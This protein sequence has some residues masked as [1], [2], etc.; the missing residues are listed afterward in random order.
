[1]K[2]KNQK[3]FT[4]IE[5]LGAVAILGILTTVGIVSVSKVLEKSHAKFDKN[6]YEVFLN[7]A[8]TYF[9]DD[10]TRLPLTPNERKEI[11][12]EKLIEYK[13]LDE[14]L[15]SNKNKF[16]YKKSRVVVIRLSTGKYK[17]EAELYRTTGQKIGTI[18][19]NKVNE[20][21][22]I[23]FKLLN[24]ESYYQEGTIYYVKDVP[25]VEVTIVDNDKI[26]GY[27]YIIYKDGKQ[28]KKSN[29]IEIA[30]VNTYNDTIEL[31][32]E[33]PFGKY[34][35]KVTAYDKFG[36]KT[37][38]TS[39]SS[40][41][42]GTSG[43]TI[44]IDRI[45]PEC[46]IN[47][48][49]LVG[50]NGWYKEQNVTLS[51][52]EKD[53][54]SGILKHTLQTNNN[55]S[56]L[57][58]LTSVSNLSKIQG[59]TAGVTWYGYVMDKA[60]N[61]CEKTATLKVDTQKPECGFNE[62]DGSRVSSRWYNKET[63]YKIDPVYL[64]KVDNGPSGI[65]R[66]NI[67]NTITDSD[68]IDNYKLYSN[69]ES[70]ETIEGIEDYYGFVRDAAGNYNTCSME[71]KKDITDPECEIAI[72][73]V[74]GDNDWYKE[75]AIDLTLI[76]SD[77]LSGIDKHGLQPDSENF[78]NLLDYT[79][80][81]IRNQ[82]DTA[83]T[84]WY[85]MVQDV[86]G[87]TCTTSADVKVDT[88]KPE[89]E[90]TDTN[91]NQIENR[92]YYNDRDEAWRIQL[93][94]DDDGPSGTN[95]YIIS[96]T[97]R[98]LYQSYPN[99][100]NIGYLYTIEGE[101]IYYGYTR[102][103]AGNYNTCSAGI[104]RDVTAP[105]CPAY[106]SNKLVL[107]DPDFGC[108]R[109]N[110]GY[111]KDYYKI[112]NFAKDTDKFKFFYFDYNSR[113]GQPN[114]QWNKDQLK[115]VEGN[116]IIYPHVESKAGAKT[117]LTNSEAYRDNAIYYYKDQCVY[118][119]GYK[120]TQQYDYD[121]IITTSGCTW[122]DNDMRYWWLLVY[123][124]VGNY[125]FC[126]SGQNNPDPE[127]GEDFLTCPTISA[128]V[129]PETWT[130][131][132]VDLTF[133]N[134]NGIYDYDWY[135]DD[136]KGGW[137]FHTGNNSATSK[138]ISGEGK[139]QGKMVIYDN[140]GN[141]KECLTP[142]YYIDKTPPVCKN[143][144]VVKEN[145]EEF[146][147]D[148]WVKSNAIEAFWDCEDKDGSGCIEDAVGKK[149]TGLDDIEDK[150]DL[151]KKI[152]DKAGNTKSCKMTVKVDNVPP[153]IKSCKKNPSGWKESACYI[154]NGGG[155]TVLLPIITDNG[156][157]YVGGKFRW[158]GGENT[159]E[160]NSAPNEKDECIATF[161]TIDSFDFKELCDKVGNCRAN[162]YTS[163]SCK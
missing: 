61:V 143:P 132:S 51:L 24:R 67:S 60:G 30:E 129:A 146:D 42:G 57:P 26:I 21:S 5:L 43:F 32:K 154:K 79:S 4:L 87:N 145:G 95:R 162:N 73:G 150:V 88:K 161:N 46:F 69:H 156:S 125:R 45:K 131:Q 14:L 53:S 20:N 41:A 134:M 124:S 34:S 75:R 148:K 149:E 114:F 110:Q 126:S 16:D 56:L 109:G 142:K 64:Y 117:C 144:Y 8:Q 10:K 140:K 121:T 155:N 130:N 23:T 107:E 39:N 82:G 25:K 108:E 116:R 66:Y 63:S 50:D 102:D 77:E 74:E 119:D 81:L 71:I 1:M 19:N 96:R 18:S 2:I 3:G 59:D 27:Q 11:T 141:S 84:T 163:Y 35:I 52:T 17:Y 62:D 80:V 93:Q 94:H 76:D 36:N 106:F 47:V 105:N 153:K 55:Y 33:Y 6:Q 58:N 97:D 13:Y 40:T 72:N 158:E 139:R 12:L 147:K 137:T 98:N 31:G 115:Y 133:S 100:S 120:N 157:G 83:G 123:D 91:G 7:A 89:C 118:G 128:N 122:F 127:P 113:D 152:E 159:T 90:I 28:F 111:Y 37:T 92:W 136:G 22:G 101:N 54:E 78:T 160:Y 65:F 135:T 68:M 85:A 49:G 112:T 151:E 15:D 48:D 70:V 9:T 138:T 44:F 103:Y 99:Y 38:K 104:R 29:N 86:A